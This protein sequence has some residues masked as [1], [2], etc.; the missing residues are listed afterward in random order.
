MMKMCGVSRLKTLALTLLMTAIAPIATSQEIPQQETISIDVKNFS[1]EHWE[2]YFAD[3]DGDTVSN[4]YDHGISKKLENLPFTQAFYLTVPLKHPGESGMTTRAE[5]NSLLKLE[6]KFINRVKAVNGVYLGR[7]TGH[8]Q[9]VFL[10]LLPSAD[11]KLQK[12]LLKLFVDKGYDAEISV[13]YDPDKN[14]YWKFLYPDADSWRVLND[15]K[16]LSELRAHNDDETKARDVDH[17]S[18]F[19]DEKTAKLFAD[20]LGNAG[21]TVKGILPP[22]GEIT[23]WCVRSL[24]NGTMLLNDITH[25]TLAHS[26]FA[27]ELGGNYDGWET[28]IVSK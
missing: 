28:I 4:F 10:G 22:D 25:H 23:E 24:H 1:T 17:W 11:S 13:N 26:R 18:Y 16:V 15:M 21:Y 7:R 14:V 9:R 19:P 5:F 12:K 27:E 2:F 20:R 6:D 3:D 8:G